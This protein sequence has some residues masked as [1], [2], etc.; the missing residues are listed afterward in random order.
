M[1]L[2]SSSPAPRALLQ[3]QFPRKAG[4]TDPG[5]QPALRIYDA[6]KKA[7]ID[8]FAAFDIAASENFLAG[9]VIDYTIGSENRPDWNATKYTLMLSEN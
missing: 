1:T 9:S 5:I 4:R 8:K 6:E 7:E 3:S 2:T